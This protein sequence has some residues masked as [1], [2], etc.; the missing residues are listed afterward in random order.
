MELE[1]GKSGLGVHALDRC[2]VFEEITWAGMERNREGR[3]EAGREL[4]ES[5]KEEKEP[6]CWI[7]Y[8]LKRG[9][10]GEAQGP[11]ERPAR[12]LKGSVCEG[13]TA[14]LLPSTQQ[15]LPTRR[16]PAE[17]LPGSVL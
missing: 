8:P 15:S 5:K 10:G 1:P 9:E 4:S 17:N 2:S 13:P 6:S 12:P 7:F 11:V 16:R 3:R 14:L